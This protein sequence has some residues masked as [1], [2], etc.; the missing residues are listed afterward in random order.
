MKKYI[1]KLTALV[2]EERKA[3]MELMINEIKRLSPGKREQ[4]G[5]AI[6]KV[7]G[8]NLGKELGF[9]IIQYG[10][11]EPID[12][13]ISVGDI[14]LIS[15]GNP[16]KSD[17]TGT[18]T[19]KGGRFIKVAIENVPRW[20]LKKHVRID[21]YA[22]DV[23]FK[24]MEENLANLSIKGKDALEYSLHVRKPKKDDETILNKKLDY[25]D[26]S[27]NESQKIAVRKALASRSFFLIH[28]P[29]GT[30]KT[31]TLIELINQ[32]YF[33]GSKIL[34]TS[35]SNN[36]IDNILERLAKSNDKINLT[37]LGHPQRVDKENI[38][39]TLAY[40]VENH[41]LNERIIELRQ[42]ADELIEKRD[43]FTK[44]SPRY[45]RGYSD[46]EIY[47]LG[48]MRKGGRG[49]SPAIMNSMAKW[50]EQ[51]KNVD[52]ILDNIK[53]IEENIIK[54]IINKSDVI[55]STNSSAALESIAKTKFDVAIID[56]ASQATIPSVLIPIAKADKFVLAGDH[57]Q[58]PPT[59]ISKKALELEDTLFESL[60]NKYPDK[61]ALLNIQ[62]RMNNLLMEFPN[63]EF[64]NSKLNSAENVENILITDIIEENKLSEIEDVNI[65]DQ[66]L[67]T[68]QP[69][70]FVDTSKL[71]KNREKQLKDS[72]SII[73][74]AEAEVTLD[75]AEFYQKL[76]VADK[77][78]GII[79]PYADQVNLIK[80]RS[81]F[82]VK[83]VDGF[84]GREKEIIIISTVRSNDKGRIGFLSDLRRL[85]VALTRAK[86]KLIVIG[87]KETLKVNPTYKRLIEY[88]YENDAVVSI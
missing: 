5:R 30:G 17:L 4:L 3:E 63:S 88:A 71:S 46:S 34:A 76:G 22:N 12:T 42:K 21:L 25:V 24:R 80:S 9:N 11:R 87:N 41:P 1:K 82:E 73:N 72:K 81:E 69:L 70:I 62:Y 19:E 56:E 44:P 14:V 68:K 29:F 28:G 47:R 75:I 74:L 61:S 64:Y 79:S 10:R 48:V 60:I 50:I 43:E 49:I 13:E 55:L 6:N 39:F 20:A 27:L 84:Q 53:K 36:A 32:E 83:T 77:D 85:N 23:T 16:L 54:D 59:I 15:I 31:R 57:K 86:R 38:R 40:K 58:L 35:E 18:V 2:D 65:E 8:K 37:R 26:D 52:E 78:I 67:S 7:K 45:K 51:N 33:M 66:L